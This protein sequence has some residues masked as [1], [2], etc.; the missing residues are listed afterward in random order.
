MTTM[1]TQSIGRPAGVSPDTSRPTNATVVV[2]YWVTTAIIAFVL[3][4]G[5]AAY[6]TR[7]PAV[8]EGIVR[9]GYPL[10]LLT[11]L[12]VWKVLGGLTLLVPRLP[13]LKEWAYAGV[14]FDFT[15][16]AASHGFCGDYGPYAFHLIV[17]L[18]LAALAAASWLLRP[19]SRRL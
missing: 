8:V 17:P 4:S 11:I 18:L 3:L 12:G 5:G 2:I 10:Y 14:I 6:L 19:P 1:Q 13:T 16:A 9:L 15:G 7:P